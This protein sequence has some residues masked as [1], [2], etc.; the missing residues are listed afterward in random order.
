MLTECCTLQPCQIASTASSHNRCHK[1]PTHNKHTPPAPRRFQAKLLQLHGQL[2][3]VEYAELAASEE[4]GAKLRE[5][6]LMPALP[7][8]LEAL[9][10]LEGGYAVHNDPRYRLRPAMPPR[11]K[12][13]VG[14]RVREGGALGLLLAGHA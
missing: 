5:W 13:Q 1:S 11:V 4:G 8:P 10:P 3:L 9:P 2:A 6:F 14:G 7:Q 12:N